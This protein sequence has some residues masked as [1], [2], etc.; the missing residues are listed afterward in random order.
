MKNFE[1]QNPTRIVFGKGTIP[2]LSRLVPTDVPVLLLYGGGSIRKNGV[3]DRVS[4]TLTQHRIHEFGG[5]TP[6]PLYETCMEALEVVRCEKIEF[7]LSVGG[8]SVLD[9]AKFIAAAARFEAGDPW[10]I[11]SDGAQVDD[12]LP[13]GAVLTLPAT[14]S[15][16]NGNSVISRESTREKLPFSSEK[17]YPVFSILD[18]E[19]TFTLPRNQVR[20]GV[21]DAFVHV[22]EQ[23]ATYDTR[24]P[25]Q[26]RIAEGVLQTLVEVGRTTLNEPRNYE[27][28]AA[29]MWSATMALQGLIGAGVVHDWSTHLIGHEFHPVGA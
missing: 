19:T 21:V 6:N 11:V 9:A 16:S 17:V 23:Y 8:G 14:G 20:N 28:R 12:A 25:V 1:F 3:Y 4:S 22:I 29:F 7:L 26:D 15:E 2:R 5:V 24:T 18:P 13:V 27:A 10:Q